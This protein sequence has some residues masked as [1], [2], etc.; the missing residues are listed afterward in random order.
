MVYH[1]ILTLPLFADITDEQVAR[2]I[3]AVRSGVREIRQ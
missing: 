3:R 2:V 1:E